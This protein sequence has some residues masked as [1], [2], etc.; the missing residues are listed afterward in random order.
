M[1]GYLKSTPIEHVEIETPLIVRRHELVPSTIGHGCYRG[2]ASVAIQLECRAPEAI[3]TVRGLD[4]F[5]L[6]PWG[7]YGG[8]PGCNGQAVLRQ[9]IIT[10]E[11]GKIKVLTMRKGDVLLMTS[12]SG[13]G[14]GDPRARDPDLVLRDVRDELISAEEAATVY[15]VVIANDEVDR[16]RTTI[17][18]ENVPET[19]NWEIA[20]GPERERYE[21]IWPIDASIAL[22]EAAMRIPQG[23]RRNVLATARRELMS[24]EKPITAEQAVQ[25][26]ERNT[27]RI[28]PS[29]L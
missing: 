9:G 17:L 8:K 7:A 21:R 26:V 6:Q 12:P 3:V 24:L 1:I 25:A 18:R 16:E 19:T 29:S 27:Q 15:G 23:I 5:R 13:G 14:F 4:R 10:R 20:S 11:I 22:A 28:A 2:G